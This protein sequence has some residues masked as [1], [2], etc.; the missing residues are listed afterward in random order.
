MAITDE[1]VEFADELGSW[2]ASKQ[3]FLQD[4]SSEDRML[5]KQWL[6]DAKSQDRLE[7][8]IRDLE[9]K[10][11]RVGKMKPFIEGLS[12]LDSVISPVA[13]LVPHGIGVML[14][15]SV[16]VLLTLATTAIAFFESVAEF[17]D[18][19]GHE[20]G[21]FRA[22]EPLY[23]KHG[24][25][26]FN[27]SLQR[28]Y[29]SYLYFCSTAK[30]FYTSSKW[31][32][33]VVS[34]GLARRKHSSN[35]DLAVA[36]VK[37]ACSRAKAEVDLVEKQAQAAVN[38]VITDGILQVGEGVQNL[39]FGFRQGLGDLQE[40]IGEKLASIDSSEFR[41]WLK[42]KNLDIEAALQTN[43]DR[44]ADLPNTCSWVFADEKI[45]SWASSAPDSIKTLWIK[46]D[47]GFGKSVLTSYIVTEMQKLY[48]TG[49]AYFFCKH[50]VQQQ[51]S[52]LSILRTW[53]WQLMSTQTIGGEIID[54]HLAILPETVIDFNNR[55]DPT[56][57]AMKRLME[58][59][60]RQNKPTRL[61]V[62]GLDECQVPSDKEKREWDILFDVLAKVPSQWK[63]LIVS[64]PHNWYNEKIEVKVGEDLKQKYITTEDNADDL[65]DFAMHQVDKYG[66]DND[67]T[68][69][70]RTE[71][72]ELM[73]DKAHG[74]LMWVYLLSETFAYA[75]PDEIQSILDEPPEGL[76]ELYGRA[77]ESL[78]R[79]N[80]GLA[81]K[82]R[83]TLKWILCCY[84]PLRLTE[85]KAVLSM[86]V[87]A[88]K[89]NIF[90]FIGPL[91]KIEGDRSEIRL[92]HASARDYLLSPEAKIFE[93]SSASVPEQLANIHA[94][95]LKKC[96]EYLSVGERQFVHVDP[97][98]EASGDRFREQLSNDP[99]L[100][101]SCNGWIQHF[102]AAYRG[103]SVLQG[104]KPQ[105]NFMLNS[106]TPVVKWLQMF[107]FLW[108]IHAPSDVARSFIGALTYCPPGTNDWADFLTNN[109]PNFVNHLS[110]EDGQRYT[111]W[112][113][114]MH[115]RHH[116]TIDHPFSLYQSPQ[117]MPA[118]SVAAFFDYDQEVK[119]MIAAGTDVNHKGPL[120][121]TPLHWAA[122][123]G[124]CK[125]MRVLIEAK[126]NK[127]ASYGRHHETPIFRGIRVPKVVPVRPGQFPAA[128]IL[129]EE[130][131][132]LEHQP[133]SNGFLGASA[134]I[135]LVEEGP[136]C[137]GAAEFAR[138]LCVRD[139]AA[140]WY[141]LHLGTI[142]QVAAWYNRQQ[143]LEELLR[144]PQQK[145][146]LN[147]QGVSTR[148]RAVLHDA[149]TQDNP[150]ITK[151]LLQAGADPNL[152]CVL[153][154]F[155]PLH[156]AVCAGVSTIDVLLDHDPPANA[157]E[158]DEVIGVRADLAAHEAKQMPLHLAVRYNTKVNF[159]KF[160]HNGFYVD[161]FDG[162]GDTPLTI[163]LENSNFEIAKTLLDLGAD[164]AKIPRV[165]RVYLP[166][167]ER[168]ERLL[169]IRSMHWGPVESYAYLYYFR[170]LT[171]KKIP[172]PILNHIL[173]LAGHTDVLTMTRKGR[174]TVNEHITRQIPKPYIMSPPIEGNA[175]EPVRRIE[176]FVHSRD[177]GHS[178]IGPA[179]SLSKL[180]TMDR[181][182][183]MVNWQ[184]E[185]HLGRN[186]HHWQDDRMI[187]TKKQVPIRMGKVR[188]G[189]RVAIFP[190]ANSPAFE[191]VIDRAEIKF[192]YGI[193]ASFTA[194]DVR[195]NPEKDRFDFNPFD[196]IYKRRKDRRT[197]PASGQDAFFVSQIGD[198]NDV[199]FGV[200]DGVGGWVDSG[201]DPADFAH[202][203]CD[204]MA[205]RA[206]KYETEG[207]KYGL[208]AKSLMQKGYD[209]IVAEKA[210]KAGG[211]TA[212]V[213]IARDDGEVDVANLGDSGF[214]Q[215]RLNAVHDYS[216][217]QTHA[218][219]TPYQLSIIPEAMKVRNAA[220]GGF[221]FCDYPKDA[222]VTKHE[223]RHGDVLV[224]A[225]DGV[226]DNLS[227][228][229]I[230]RVVSRLMVGARAWEH[231]AAGIRVSDKLSAFTLPDE[232]QPGAKAIPT[233]QSFLA[234][235]IT[236][237]AKA[238]SINTKHDGPF[239]KEVQKYYPEESWKGGKIDDICVIVAIVV[240]DNL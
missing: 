177:Q 204:H 187:L 200:A 165:L 100:E 66:T 150:E 134:L 148:L 79:Q 140:Y 14:W 19:I 231:T 23:S 166:T 208:T 202:G 223:V 81:T 226:W 230:L 78:S 145:A 174:M 211:S 92:V 138:A 225:T 101:Y 236:G 234:V 142:S 91:I 133:R 37:V 161:Q 215:L 105:L 6:S 44:R 209:D 70:L 180:V 32:K 110:W 48:P 103:P 108:N 194:K 62:D 9:R 213:A 190:Y 98:Q 90:K 64:R 178:N 109:Y 184:P 93:E 229:D 224:F 60:S 50:D 16:K 25:P 77:L 217:P 233:L 239:A 29:S 119:R 80:K 167:Q 8:E 57:F 146:L 227:S 18:D 97:N 38:Q 82:V 170:Q 114:F 61:I 85:L 46:A 107:H 35:I 129:F 221:Q 228:S 222:S 54:S 104:V 210:V 83:L 7:K 130:G 153:N 43:I 219:N 212:C 65:S 10:N 34:T 195:Y 238:A 179:Y 124:S 164:P 136:D 149:C 235:G 116:Y 21:L 86:S 207:T 33:F 123:G 171:Q 72:L 95:I 163:A 84:R 144:V 192:S 58:Q 68:P 73:L 94:L 69:Q 28:V 160:I 117:V 216:E 12:G 40:S 53:I 206:N 154:G 128:R 89:D 196:P 143:I 24:S 131:V 186:V 120:D 232:P 162:I 201:V 75:A 26:R 42:V 183:I 27:A 203:F 4:L 30:D 141:Y 158:T 157:C 112:D 159:G 13:D 175:A 172:I 45:K 51:S 137:Q 5:F 71:I 156:F 41:G 126:A 1:G 191:N 74:N 22:Y 111:R 76:G 205:Y 155:T 176:T 3:R 36:E 139:P 87:T 2:E 118:I 11:E 20:L 15:G 147:T 220:F 237:E 214:V 135:A 122:T 188:P 182:L 173:R 56:I 169:K 52:V 125:S 185:H 240:Q 198:S 168:D 193:A 151:I 67:W 17:L 127:E 63:V 113:R 39:E 181:N 106:D 199:A 218:F 31:R 49:V 55:G 96:L 99:L 197:R 88:V 115:R 152:G 102:V 132:S 47:A 121:G 189:E 59:L